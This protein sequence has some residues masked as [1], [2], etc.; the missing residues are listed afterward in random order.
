MST[1]IS[2]SNNTVQNAVAARIKG[3]S[4]LVEA[5]GTKNARLEAYVLQNVVYNTPNKTFTAEITTG[6]NPALIVGSLLNVILPQGE[7]RVRVTN[8]VGTSPIVGT[9]Q[10]DSDLEFSRCWPS[11]N[12]RVSSISTAATT[13]INLQ[14]S[15]SYA[16][17]LKTSNSGLVFV[18]NLS[19]SQGLFEISNANVTLYGL[20]TLQAGHQVSVV[21]LPTTLSAVSGSISSTIIGNNNAIIGEVDSATVIGK[22]LTATS[23]HNNSLLTRNIHTSAITEEIV[24]VTGSSSPTYQV[25]SLSSTYTVRH[26]SSGM[27]TLNI[28]ELAK[29]RYIHI[30]RVGNKAAGSGV[31]IQGSGITLDG[32][33]LPKVILEKDHNVML[34][35]I[36]ST[37]LVT[38]FD[39]HQTISAYLKAD[40]KPTVNSQ[41]S[42]ELTDNNNLTIYVRD[43]AG[44]LKKATLPLT[45]V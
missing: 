18:P 25:N 12:Y 32:V 24:E 39:S 42:V 36:S 40:N 33:A 21:E 3:S 31:T 1:T 44:V 10:I 5:P 7:I 6:S 17:W 20:N 15:F 35:A 2:G 11:T 14:D 13:V 34:K 26:S 16:G 29:G 38:V 30:H 28:T 9:F 4:N 43:T 19:A 22:N 23:V 27:T 8:L 37:Q 45:V 41:M